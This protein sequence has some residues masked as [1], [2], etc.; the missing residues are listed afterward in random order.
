MR[1]ARDADGH[2]R[3]SALEAAARLAL[4]GGDELGVLM[5]HRWAEDVGAGERVLLHANEARRRLGLEPAD[6]HALT[7][8]QRVARGEELLARGSTPE[9][10]SALALVFREHAVLPPDLRSRLAAAY[11]RALHADGRTDDAVKALRDVA[12]TLD[13][14]ADREG[15]YLL[16]ADAVRVSVYGLSTAGAPQEDGRPAARILGAF[17]NPTSGGASLVFDLSAGGAAS[18]RRQVAV[19][20]YDLAGRRV[21]TVHQGPA[22]PGRVEFRWD[23]RT[24]AGLPAAA[25]IYFFRA[26]VDEQSAVT[27]PLRNEDGW[28]RFELPLPEGKHRLRFTFSADQPAWRL[29]GF[30]AEVRTP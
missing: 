7:A 3:A 29:P 15:L 12:A 4:E 27:L 30:H 5:L 14:L 1:V 28:K 19:S 6:L 11:A 20:V 16:A 22:D 18:G 17:P 24:D 25:G 2:Q 23:G 8:E 9:A 13:K 26:Q 10:A 21:R